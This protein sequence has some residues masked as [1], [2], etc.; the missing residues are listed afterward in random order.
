MLTTQNYL[1]MHQKTETYKYDWK[2]KRPTGATSGHF[3]MGV[4]TDA[5]RLKVGYFNQVWWK[6]KVQVAV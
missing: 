4:I 2:V 3:I 6:L 1:E 5:G